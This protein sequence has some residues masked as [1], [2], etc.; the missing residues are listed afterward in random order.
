MKN[1]AIEIFIQQVYGPRI[2]EKYFYDDLFFT[3]YLHSNETI[4]FMH[5]KSKKLK[6]LGLFSD[7]ERK[8][9]MST[10]NFETFHK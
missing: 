6:V 10:L 4:G 2:S 7:F 5:G 1:T 3:F 9:I 8:K